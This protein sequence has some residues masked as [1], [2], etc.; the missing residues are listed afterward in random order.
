MEHIV[1]QDLLFF[2]DRLRTISF[3]DENQAS[4]LMTPLGQQPQFLPAPTDPAVPL[5]PTNR[6]P[7]VP[8]PV[9]PPASMVRPPPPPFPN[10]GLRLPIPVGFLPRAPF[11]APPGPPP[12]PP[13]ANIRALAGSV[14][15]R[16]FGSALE[17]MP[18][19]LPPLPA[20]PNPQLPS[21]PRPLLRDQKV[22]SK[23][24]LSAGPKLLQQLHQQREHQQEQRTL[25]EKGPKSAEAPKSS[26]GN[27]A[28][29]VATPILRKVH[30]G[31]TR[32]TPTAVKV[33]R[34]NQ[35]QAAN[36]AKKIAKKE[37]S[38]AD[39][40]PTVSQQ[41]DPKIK[42]NFND[43]AYEDFMKEIEELM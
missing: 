26:P 33:K 12:G 41:A 37:T 35:Q 27:G 34:S 6:L 4:K 20:L 13:P 31:V 30:P 36:S 22:L 10:T 24:V 5:L 39:S 23:P 7:F 21:I 19:R 11:G 28:T 38:S 2:S 14:I 1:K 25:I 43:M 3:S 9:C 17:N 32:F 42:A 18:G 8:P 29:I 40:M 15:V 16:Q